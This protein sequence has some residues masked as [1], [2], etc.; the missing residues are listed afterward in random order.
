[1]SPERAEE[2][3]AV[4][5][6][7]LKILTGR[8]LT[9]AECVQVAWANVLSASVE[10]TGSLATAA[11]MLAGLCKMVQDAPPVMLHVVTDGQVL[12]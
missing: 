7:L 11:D 2:L 3:R 12:N 4:Q 8:G 6:D 10:H 9:T 5:I 1:M